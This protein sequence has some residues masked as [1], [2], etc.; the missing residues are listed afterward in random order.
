MRWSALFWLFLCVAPAHAQEKPVVLLLDDSART[1]SG[2]RFRV[3]FEQLPIGDESAVWLDKTGKMDSI[4]VGL[5]AGGGLI[6]GGLADAH[7]QGQ[8]NDS[9]QSLRTAVEDGKRLEKDIVSAI[10][11]SAT[12]HGYAVS[13]TYLAQSVDAGFVKRVGQDDGEAVVVKR[14]GYPLVMLSW[15]DRRPLLA[16]DV[17][18]L[19]RSEG[20]RGP[21][22]REKAAR[23]VRYVGY[24]APA[25]AGAVEYWAANGG[26]R[27]MAEVNSGLAAMLSLAWSNDIDV[28]SVSRKETVALRVGDRDLEFTGRLWKQEGPLAYVFNSDH[29][30]TVVRTQ[31][32]I[33]TGA[34][35]P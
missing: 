12:A 1:V 5:L 6:G 8:R 14:D 7:A 19:K 26:A 2:A 9:I 17:R 10:Q 28:P 32:L 25:T 34:G 35:V 29:G 4:A 21:V 20:M 15:D 27:F 33:D 16:F 3:G 24:P 31:P 22:I 23:E 30:I 11:A 18:R 13:E